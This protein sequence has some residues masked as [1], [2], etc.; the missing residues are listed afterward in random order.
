M[1]DVVVRTQAREL[2]Q[3]GDLSFRCR[4]IEM[5]VVGRSPA[6]PSQVTQILF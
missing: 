2:G 5:R 1:L 3:F 4:R 6:Y